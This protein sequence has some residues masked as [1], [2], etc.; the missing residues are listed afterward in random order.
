M[1]KIALFVAAIFLLS[2]VSAQDSVENSGPAEPKEKDFKALI[3]K[4]GRKM[5]SELELKIQGKA[6]GLI[7]FDTTDKEKGAML[8]DIYAYY[9]TGANFKLLDRKELDKV[10]E[11]IQLSFEMVT[12]KKNMD[13]IGKQ[14][15]ADFL[16]A[17]NMTQFEDSY[18][19]NV[20][21]VDVS[22]GE[23]IYADSLSFKNR[24][25]MSVKNINDLIP[26]RKYPVSALFR[27]ALIPGWGQFYN[28]KPVKGGI[29]LGLHVALAATTIT[30]ACL[31][32]DDNSNSEDPKV[33]QKALDEGNRNKYVFAGAVSALGVNLII[34]MIDAYVDAKRS[35]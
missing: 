20:K 31:H 10:L 16:Q 2:S 17:G 3:Q 14:T 22:T 34:S 1:K 32:W 19:I 25:F 5:R 9:L 30:F 35:K 12:E 33:Q 13:K 8:S 7:S 26:E 11:E 23:S 15:G 27:S 18:Y 6:L 29:F 28:D 24:D 4:S 21:V